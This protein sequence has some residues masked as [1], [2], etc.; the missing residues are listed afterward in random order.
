MFAGIMVSVRYLRKPIGATWN[1]NL[2]HKWYGGR[3]IICASNYYLMWHQSAS[4]DIWV[5]RRC[6]LCLIEIVIL[7]VYYTI[8]F[9]LSV[10][11]HFWV[12]HFNFLNYFV[13][14][15]ITDEGSLP[16]MRIWSILLIKSDLKWC[17]HLRRSLCIFAMGSA[18]TYTV[19]DEH[20]L[21]C[22]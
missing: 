16:E 11:R 17:I 21:N 13:W 20:T 1:N 4:V 19:A 6:F 14:L 10:F 5:F 9:G 22:S 15:R 7:W 8:P 2:M 18:W 3:H 12:S